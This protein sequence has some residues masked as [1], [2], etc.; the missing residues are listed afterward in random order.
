MEW[1]IESY[2]R[3]TDRDGVDRYT[4]EGAFVVAADELFHN[5]RRGFVAARLP[6]G[7]VLN[8]AGLRDMVASV[9]AP[10]LVQRKQFP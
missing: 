3:S 10:G 6:D 7:T 2:D 4:T 1:I 5:S 9:P 8:E